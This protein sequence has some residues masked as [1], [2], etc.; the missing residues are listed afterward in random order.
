MNIIMIGVTYFIL[1][2][3]IVPVVH[4]VINNLFIT[5]CTT[6]TMHTRTQTTLSL[7]TYYHDALVM[8]I[9]VRATLYSSLYTCILVIAKPV[10]ID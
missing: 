2:V 8:N 7:I 10:T 5:L 4:K 9:R 3:C 6:G 1:F